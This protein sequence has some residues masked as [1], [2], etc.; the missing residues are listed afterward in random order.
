M[1][2]LPNYKLALRP[3]AA[4]MAAL[5]TIAA[6][7]RATG[8]PYATRSDALRHALKVVAS[9]VSASPAVPVAAPR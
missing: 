9:A 1:R 6:A 8:K 5:D 4:D 7:L 2:T 3:T